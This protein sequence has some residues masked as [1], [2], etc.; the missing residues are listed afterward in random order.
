[1]PTVA[2]ATTAPEGSVTRPRKI[3]LDEGDAVNGADDCVCECAGAD[4]MTTAKST[5]AQTIV[6]FFIVDC[7]DVMNVDVSNNDGCFKPH[8]YFPGRSD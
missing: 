5:K 3:P 4:R 7:F 1:M 8:L 6:I 2:F